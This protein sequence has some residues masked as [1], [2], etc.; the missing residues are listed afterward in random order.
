MRRGGEG[1]ENKVGTYTVPPRHQ[2][3]FD[4][5]VRKKGGSKQV[6]KD[7]KWEEATEKEYKSKV[8]TEQN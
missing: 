2:L 5:K 6:Y 7:G 3:V 1:S 4:Q 8:K